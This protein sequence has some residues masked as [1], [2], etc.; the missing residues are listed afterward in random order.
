M[1]VEVM[2]MDNKDLVVLQMFK[3][4]LKEHQMLKKLFDLNIQLGI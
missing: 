4:L 1:V 3:H 2:S